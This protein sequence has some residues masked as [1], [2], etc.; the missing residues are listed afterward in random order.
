MEGA[1][2][3]KDETE[4]LDFEE[5]VQFAQ[6]VM[7]AFPQLELRLPD[8]TF[9]DPVDIKGSKRTV[10]FMTF[11]GGHTDSDAFLLLPLERVIFTGDLL[12]V[13][14][15]PALFK[16]HPRKW[17]DIL[18]QM[19]ALQPIYLIPGHGPLATPSDLAKMERYIRETLQ[20]AEL[21]WHQ[22]GTIESAAALQPPAFTK[23][24]DNSDIFGANMKFLHEVVQQTI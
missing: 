8:Y 21:H 5:G 4:R 11:G 10:R 2:A 19:K 1:R 16:G 12:V 18:M 23:G 7:A 15:H 3:A 9:S 20:M 6:K 17:L 13:N 22:G 14:N 24:W